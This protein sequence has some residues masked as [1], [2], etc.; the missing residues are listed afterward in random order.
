MRALLPRLVVPAFLLGQAACGDPIDRAS[1]VRTMRVLAVQADHAFAKPGTN[2]LLRMLSYDGSP[3][4]VR[5]DG[6]RRPVHVLWMSACSNPPGDL[7]YNCYPALHASMAGVTDAGLQ[8]EQIPKDVGG[9]GQELVVSIP[10]DAITSRP[11]KS[12]VIHPYGMVYVFYLAC[13]GELRM[14]AAAD[15]LRDSPVGCFEPTTGA[16]SPI[17]DFEFGY[18]PIFV[19]DNLDNQNPGLQQ[20]SFQEWVTGAPCISAASCSSGETCGTEG[21]CIRKVPQ[22]LEDDADKCP[23]Y[24]FVPQVD[25]ASLEHAVT[26]NLTA[27]DAPLETLWVSY[28]A[29]AGSFDKDLRLVH[30]PESGWQEGYHGRW[31]A[32]VAPGTQVRLW[33]VLRDNRNGVAWAWQDVFVD[34]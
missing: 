11:Q 17:D 12:E 30:D 24:P 25:P 3:R 8:A 6:T 19:Y 14:N 9:F 16:P 29:T 5:A 18:F 21:T 26:A 4:A 7:Y 34:E 15:P 28:F 32:T 20:V 22:C 1:D 23:S 10:Q 13:A 2:V 33:A 31:R 27:Q